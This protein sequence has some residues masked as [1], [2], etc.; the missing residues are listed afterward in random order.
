MPVTK[1]FTVFLEDRAGTLGRLCQALA[2][3]GVNILALHSFPSEGKSVTR[4]IVDNPGEA[5][6]ALE[7]ERLTYTEA[8]V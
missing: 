7:G 2:D 6:S 8:D 3:R 5:T 4:L 1:E